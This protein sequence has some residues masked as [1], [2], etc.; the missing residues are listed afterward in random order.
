MAK[1]K[2]ATLGVVATAA[3]LQISVAKANEVYITDF[4]KNN[5]IYTDLNQQFPN[6]GPGVPGSGTGNAN[7]SYLYQAS[8]GINYQLTSNASG[9]DFAQIGTTGGQPGYTG[10][11]PLTVAVGVQDV[12]SV[13]FL[14]AAYNSQSFSVTFTGSGGATETFNNVS[15]PDFNGGGPINTNSGGVSTQTVFQVSDQGGGGTGNSSTGDT[16][17]YDLT[18]EGF[19]L[20]SDFADQTLASATITSNGYETLLLGVTVENTVTGAVPELSTWAMMILGFCG[21]GFMAYRRRQNGAAL[22]VA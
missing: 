16:T 13:Y 1:L 21:L 22:R 20:D 15:V 6:T 3:I 4:A 9:Q 5:S 7:A 17:T 10:P 12:S 18:Q 14:M 11:N 8:S 19:T 2:F